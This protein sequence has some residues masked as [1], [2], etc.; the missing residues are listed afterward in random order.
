[1]S[2]R[3]SA[4]RDIEAGF[5]ALIEVTENIS[6]SV[7]QAESRE[8]IGLIV[9]SL[10]KRA[11]IMQQISDMQLRLKAMPED[12]KEAEEF[13]KHRWLCHEMAKRLQET[14]QTNMTV[15]NQIMDKYMDNVRSTKQSIRAVQAYNM[16]SARP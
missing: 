9:E 14:D 11:E 15:L 4:I 8:G 13:E 3:L 10:A 12:P 2:E 7:E 1:M 16:Q 5:K 6:S